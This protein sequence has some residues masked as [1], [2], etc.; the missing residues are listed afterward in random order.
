MHNLLIL[1]CNDNH[2]SGALPESLSKLQ[3][4][5]KLWVHRNDLQGSCSEGHIAMDSSVVCLD[6][7][8][9]LPTGRWLSRSASS[10]HWISTSCFRITSKVV[11]Q[12][13]SQS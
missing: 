3:K 2:F 12:P 8:S 6:S 4:L 11:M 7:C 10:E 5:L 9:C 1:G 13:D